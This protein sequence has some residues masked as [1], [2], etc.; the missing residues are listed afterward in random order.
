M[1]NR[2]QN[3]QTPLTDKTKQGTDTM[4]TQT[5]VA[6]HRTMTEKHPIQIF[7][8]F[9]LITTEGPESHKNGS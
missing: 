2:K 6:I 7:L 5:A 8:F 4:D 1:I 3:V 9:H